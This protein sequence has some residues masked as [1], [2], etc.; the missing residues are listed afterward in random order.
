M[1]SMGSI[2]AGRGQSFP[3]KTRERRRATSGRRE[4][5]VWLVSYAWGDITPEGRERDKIVD[6]L[7]CAARENGFTIL[8]DKEVLRLGDRISDFMRRM[9]V[10]DRVF[11]VLSDKYLR[12]AYCMNE[13]SGIWRNCR[14]DDR[15]FL[16]R[17]RVYTL[18]DAK[19]WTPLD[20]AKYAAY[21]REQCEKIALLTKEHGVDLL[22][23]KDYEQYRLM[24][25]FSFHIGDILATVADVL[26]PRSFDE[27]VKYGFNPHSGKSRKR[28]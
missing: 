5:C 13:L 12:S 25:E 10:G 27:L 15:A 8:R 23:T 2:G 17:V 28:R 24:R 26:Q 21:W 18:E 16:R 9:V 3:K 19:I 6:T 1:R 22:G 4:E 11:V 7:C 14:Q 20:R